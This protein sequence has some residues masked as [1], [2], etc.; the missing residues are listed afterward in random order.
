MLRVKSPLTANQE[1]IVSQAMD[2]AF[3]VHRALGP[4]FRERIYE[5]AFCLELGSTALQF[6][7]QKPIL[8]TYKEWQIPGQK[9]D[10]IVEGIVLVEIKAIPRL[11]SVHR[12]QVISYLKTLN[13]RVGLLINFNVP[14]LKDG[15]RRIVN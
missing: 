6:E 9:V 10:L 3:T 8:V 4:G 5:R 14:V 2:C 12:A 7:T 11:L 1:R 13:L 15:F